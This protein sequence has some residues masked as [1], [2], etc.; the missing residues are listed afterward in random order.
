MISFQKR[1]MK[2]SPGCLGFAGDWTT[3]LCGDYTN[4]FQISLLNSIMESKAVFFFVAHMP[5]NASITPAADKKHNINLT[6]TSDPSES[7]GCTPPLLVYR[8]FLVPFF[9]YK[10]RLKSTPRY[11][12]GPLFSLQVELLIITPINGWKYVGKWSYFTLLIGVK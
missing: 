7:S 2:T 12:R 10:N 1:A 3:Q 9:S 11:Y 4:P 6:S 5:W 8:S